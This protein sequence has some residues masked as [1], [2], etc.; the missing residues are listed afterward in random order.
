MVEAFG[1]FSAMMRIRLEKARGFGTVW[2]ID[3]LLS[4]VIGNE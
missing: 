3:S 4:R 1:G 2:M